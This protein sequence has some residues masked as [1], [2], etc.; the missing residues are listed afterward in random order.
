MVRLYFNDISV[1][2]RKQE[3]VQKKHDIRNVSHIVTM[4]VRLNSKELNKKK[5]SVGT[6]RTGKLRQNGAD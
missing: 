6:L 4:A 3:R 1:N 2:K 5:T